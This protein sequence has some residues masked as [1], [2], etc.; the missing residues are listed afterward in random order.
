MYLK[1]KINFGDIQM[2]MEEALDSHSNISNPTINDI[3]D[4]IV[5]T[6]K[7]IN[8]FKVPS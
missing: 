3:K 5:L 4:T 6:E 1:N 7:F 2:L 8:N